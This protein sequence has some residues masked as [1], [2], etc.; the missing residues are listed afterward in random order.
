MK[1]GRKIILYF[2]VLA[3]IGLYVVLYAVPSL[4]GA[5]TK[6]EILQYEAFQV[7]DETTCYFVREEQVY[8]AANSGEINYYLEDGVQVRKGARILTISPERYEA[9]GS[10]YAELI[11][12]LSDKAVTLY[13]CVAEFNGVV[14]YYV[15]GYEGRFTPENIKD[16]QYRDVKELQAEGVNVV[17]NTTLTGEPL[18]KI[19]NNHLWY[20]TCWVEPGNIGK[21]EVGKNVTV[22]LPAGEVKAVITEILDEG[23]MWQVILESNRHYPDLAKVRWV[24]ATIITFDYSGIIIRNASLTTQD[25]KVGVYVKSRNGDFVFTPVKSIDSDGEVTVVESSYFYDEEGHRV[26]TVDIYDEILKE[27]S[28]LKGNI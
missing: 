20:L 22:K 9:E 1:K 2:F 24:S 13:D 19:C 6:T 18:Y 15:D 27:P 25:G 7:T 3:L 17:R 21:Y 10:A 12:K 23:D 5:L 14:G 4:T 11:T 28:Q 8:M 26:E 16:I